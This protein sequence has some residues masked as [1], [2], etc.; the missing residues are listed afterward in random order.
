MPGDVGVVLLAWVEIL[1]Q[2]IPNV[3][4]PHYLAP[5]RACRSDLEYCLGI[6]S[7]AGDSCRIAAGGDGFRARVQL[8][9]LHQYVTVGQGRDVVVP[10]IFVV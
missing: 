7:C 8:E 5:R 10:Q 6:E 2:V 1:H 4:F 9:C 3:P